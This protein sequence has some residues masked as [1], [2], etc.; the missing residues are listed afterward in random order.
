MYL[1]ALKPFVNKCSFILPQ[2][3]KGH[4]VEK[5]RF[6]GEGF[7]GKAVG[8]GYLFPALQSFWLLT[9]FSAQATLRAALCTWCLCC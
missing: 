7:T 5:L 6:Y 2:R 4:K 1:K 9:T 8:R 3:H